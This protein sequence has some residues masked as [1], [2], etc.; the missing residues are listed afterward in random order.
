MFPGVMKLSPNSVQVLHDWGVASWCIMLRIHHCHCRGSGHCCGANSI[1]GLEMPDM[2][3]EW[4]KPITNLTSFSWR[5][6]KQDQDTREEIQ[7]SEGWFCFKMTVTLL[8]LRRES[9]CRRARSMLSPQPISPRWII[10]SQTSQVER[11]NSSQTLRHSWEKWCTKWL[12]LILSFFHYGNLSRR[13]P[14]RKTETPLLIKLKSQRA[15]G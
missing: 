9:K 2:P 13:E 14:I 8:V 6:S 12:P 5:E 3:W 1:P 15:T 10:R 4:P 11:I 7:A